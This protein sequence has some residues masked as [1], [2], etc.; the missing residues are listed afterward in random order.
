MKALR[1]RW[2]APTTGHG[3]GFTATIPVYFHVFT[4]GAI[5]NLTNQQ[6]RQQINVLNADFGGFEGGAYT[7]FS[8]DLA[9]VER[10]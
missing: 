6:L 10:E 9:G 2:E 3:K 1:G 5:G 8:F 7:G 4:D